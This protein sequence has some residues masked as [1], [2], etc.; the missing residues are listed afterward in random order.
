VA[1]ALVGWVGKKLTSRQRWQEHGEELFSALVGRRAFAEMQELLAQGSN[2]LAE[3]TLAALTNALV[4]R[5]IAAIASRD[6]ATAGAL[7]SGLAC[8]DAA[9]EQQDRYDALAEAARG[10]QADEDVVVLAD[11]LVRLSRQN[12]R[13]GEALEGMVAAVHALSDAL[14]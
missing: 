7:L 11:L 4:D 14:A 3:P 5:A 9:G 8:L 6:V 13:R 2:A 10:A 1:S 12:A